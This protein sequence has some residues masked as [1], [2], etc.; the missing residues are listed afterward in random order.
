VQEP[1]LAPFAEEQRGLDVPADDVCS[2][3]I[4]Y[5][6]SSFFFAAMGVC[7][8]ALGNMGY[9][10]WEITFFRSII[11]TCLSVSA[12]TSAGVKLTIV[13]MLVMS[14]LAL[15]VTQPTALGHSSPLE[16]SVTVLCRR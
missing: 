16:L 2:G 5:M 11:I 12:I 14:Q 3:M 8:K 6:C 1:L 7:S 9:P 4:W 13:S 15:N 10:V